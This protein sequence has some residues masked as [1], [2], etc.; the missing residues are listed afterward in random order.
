MVTGF[1]FTLLVAALLWSATSTSQTK[2]VT[3]DVVDG[4]E[5]R[6]PS[7]A[8][9]LPASERE[10]VMREVGRFRHANYCPFAG[11]TVYGHADAGEGSSK[12]KDIL[13]VERGRYVAR[14]L[15]LGGIPKERIHTDG[16]G[17]RFPSV[18]PSDP[19]NARAEVSVRA[20]CA[21]ERCMFPVTASGFRLPKWEDTK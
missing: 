11:V 8:A 1:Q 7:G 13:G 3:C 21:S 17:D 6:F 5:I 2:P 18:K 9:S 15:E 4:M 10:R 20:G 19:R 14:L 16:K 12:N